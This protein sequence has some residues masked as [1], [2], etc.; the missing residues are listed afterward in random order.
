MKLNE[1]LKPSNILQP[2]CILKENRELSSN[3]VVVDNKLFVFGGNL[4]H[5]CETI[6][7]IESKNPE[8]RYIDFAGVK[9]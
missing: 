1:D 6:D 4:R 7:N 3:A 8:S 2:V 5:T 9:I